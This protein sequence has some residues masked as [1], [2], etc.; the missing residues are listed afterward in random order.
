MYKI[1]SIIALGAL[2]ACSPAIESEPADSSVSEATRAAEVLGWS[3]TVSTMTATYAT[4]GEIHAPG[5]GDVV[6]DDFD[7]HSVRG[8]LTGQ[9]ETLSTGSTRTTAIDATLDLLGV[10]DD[11]YS[12]PLSIEI[13]S[14]EHGYT[15]D[16]DGVLE[17]TEGAFVDVDLS[18][19]VSHDLDLDSVRYAGTIDG[20]DVSGRIDSKAMLDA[21]HGNDDCRA[22]VGVD[23]G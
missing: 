4:N 19:T 23:C 12:G 11:R 5:Q 10:G 9:F 15:F 21:P 22:P 3:V 17:T 6:Y 14:D 20:R 8:N 1:I 7:I 16:F 2:S 18:T 13:G